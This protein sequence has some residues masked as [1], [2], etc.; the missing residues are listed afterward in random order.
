MRLS[1]LP[2]L[3]R[4][5]DSFGG[6]SNYYKE[7][8]DALSRLKK[9]DEE[10]AE[11]TGTLRRVQSSSGETRQGYLYTIK[12]CPGYEGHV[13]PNSTHEVCKHCGSISYYH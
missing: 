8:Q 3:Q 2:I 7:Y 6:S 12:W 1:F 10:L 9:K 5:E 13:P 11:L 4:E